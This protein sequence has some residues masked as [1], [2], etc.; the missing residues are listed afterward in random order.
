MADAL[1]RKAP[2]IKAGKFL[3]G[4]VWRWSLLK[5]NF[6]G[7]TATITKETARSSQKQVFYSATKLLKYL[8]GFSYTDIGDTIN[9]M[10]LAY[11]ED[12]RV[13]GK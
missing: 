11:K 2:S 4:L 13:Q 1:G 3:T 6:F 12:L 8:P 10:A 7:E 5:A 9:R